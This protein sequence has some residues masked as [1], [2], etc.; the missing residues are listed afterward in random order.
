MHQLHQFVTDFVGVFGSVINAHLVFTKKAR[1]EKKRKVE[2]LTSWGSMLQIL[3]PEGEYLT[4][5]GPMLRILLS[6]G[7]MQSLRSD[8]TAFVL[9]HVQ[10][11]FMFSRT[12]KICIYLPFLRRSKY[13]EVTP[14]RSEL[15][16][17]FIEN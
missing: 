14:A 5:Q 8:K 11:N 6:S 1:S 17:V 12:I 10:F 15:R 4:S 9:F 2:Y 7:A 16:Q 3:S 13:S